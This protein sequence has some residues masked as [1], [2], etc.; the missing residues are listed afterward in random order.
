MSNM[1]AI[2]KAN[3]HTL[4]TVS[5]SLYAHPDVPGWVISNITSA[6]LVWLPKDQW[7]RR[8]KKDKDSLSIKF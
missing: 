3:G 1:Q 4:V 2:T 5:K 8:Y 7:H 6:H